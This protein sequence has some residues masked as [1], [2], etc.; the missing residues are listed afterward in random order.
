LTRTLTVAQNV[1][2]SSIRI[3][4]LSGGSVDQHDVERIAR[5]ALRELG[6]AGAVVT[7]APEAQTGHWRIDIHGGGHGPGQLRIK[8]GQGST[9]QWVRQQIFDQ[10][11]AQT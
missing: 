3:S 8:C 2:T 1:A 7:I 4:V 9:A 11:N 6:V 5:A 10:Y